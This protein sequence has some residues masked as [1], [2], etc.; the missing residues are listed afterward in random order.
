MIVKRLISAFVKSTRAM[1]R[2]TIYN[3]RQWNSKVKKMPTIKYQ[4]QSINNYKLNNFVVKWKRLPS[5]QS[6]L[7]RVHEEV[8][9]KCRGV[10]SIYLCKSKFASEGG[11]KI[12]FCPPSPCPSFKISNL[13][14]RGRGR[15]YNSFIEIWKY[16][17]FSGFLLSRVKNI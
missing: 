12:S 9:Y 16:L 13:R 1:K 8:L 14:G 2:T 15:K 4:T 3:I 10:H 11:E 17:L 5:N 6:C 7:I